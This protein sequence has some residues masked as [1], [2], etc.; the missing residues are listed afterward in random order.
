M[1][2]GFLAMSTPAAVLIIIL[3]IFIENGFPEVFNDNTKGKR[4]K[5]SMD[6]SDWRHILLLIIS[7]GVVIFTP[8]FNLIIA[9]L[10]T[11]FVLFQIYKYYRK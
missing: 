8:G 7:V 6:L 9:V 11:F 5:V 3:C 1:I 2:K 4:I 10:Y